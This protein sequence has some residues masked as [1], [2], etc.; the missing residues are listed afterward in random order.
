MENLAD[1]RQFVRHILGDA[2]NAVD[3]VLNTFP[4]LDRV[5]RSDEDFNV[6]R[7]SLV[8][9]LEKLFKENGKMVDYYSKVVKQ[10]RVKQEI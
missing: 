1:N 4:A 6:W 3:E 9:H 8:K 2:N 10:V 7:N 5:T